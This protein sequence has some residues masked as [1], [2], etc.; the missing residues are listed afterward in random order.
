MKDLGRADADGGEG[1]RL[2]TI[3]VLRRDR[4]MS[5]SHPAE[6]RR[7]AC[8]RRRMAVRQGFEPWVEAQHPYNGL[9]NR[10]L[11]PLGHLTARQQVYGTTIFAG[12]PEIVKAMGR[13]AAPAC[14]MPPLRRRRTTAGRRFVV[15]LGGADR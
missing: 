10:R 1:A 2:R 15:P 3:H 6:A 11:Q 7:V 13:M 4:V 12:K 9:A 5:V 8:E 14:E